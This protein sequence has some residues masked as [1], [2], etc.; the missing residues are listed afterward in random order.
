MIIVTSL[1]LENVQIHIFR[2]QVYFS[3]QE[4]KA[5][6]ASMQ[7][8]LQIVSVGNRIILV[9]AILRVGILS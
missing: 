9:A 8:K 7:V 2:C 5:H 1:P 6:E 3:F 4:K